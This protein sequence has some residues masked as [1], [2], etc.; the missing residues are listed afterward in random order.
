MKKILLAIVAGVTIC[1]CANNGTKNTMTSGLNMDSIVKDTSV[2]LTEEANSPKCEIKLSLQFVKGKNADVINNALLRS[3]ILMP[4]YLSLS[5]EKLDIKQAVD[6]FT[7]RY[8]CDYK[9]DY[10]PLYKED[11]NNS[12]SYNSIYTVKTSTQSNIE[13]IISYI[14]SI[15]YYSGGAHGTSQTIVKN[16]NIKNGKLMELKDFFVPGY[17]VGLKDL[18]VEKLAEKFKATDLKGLQKQYIFADGRAYIPENFIPGKDKFT[19]IYCSD[20]IAPHAVGE[21]RVDID[22]SDIK[23]LL[24]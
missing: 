14:A 10:A 6:S 9:T 4:D 13:N 24:K 22:K 17:E 20:E 23:D 19:F 11:K 12:G 16:F 15:Y 18:I 5:D 21:I 2:A 3:G 8:I 1:S 7:N